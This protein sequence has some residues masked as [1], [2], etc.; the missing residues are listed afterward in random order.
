M[1]NGLSRVAKLSEIT[2]GKAAIIA[3]EL[4]NNIIKHA[5]GKGEILI[6][7]IFEPVAGV[8][9]M[10]IDQGEGMVSVAA[11][12]QDGFSTS[13]TPGT[14]LGA[15][16]RL[17]SVSDIYSVPRKGTMIL[18]QVTEQETIRL[19]RASP[20]GGVCTPYPG[21]ISC[22]DRWVSVTRSGATWIMVA[23]GLG[24][25]ETAQVAADTAAELF[26]SSTEESPAIILQ[27]L[28]GALR[29]TRGAAASILKFD[30]TRNKVTYSG[31][32]NISAVMVDDNVTKH[33]VSHNGT[34]GA[35][36]RKF[37]EFEQPV[38]AGAMVIM[39]SDGLG[40]RWDLK[41]Y[42]GVLQRHPSLVAGLLYTRFKR[43]RDDVTVVALRCVVN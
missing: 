28:H 17:A 14:G 29:S 7:Q 42:P 41:E 13:G 35:E 38:R 34:L 3:T 22:G 6:R 33:L 26:L 12:S 27:H 9:I 15:V 19:R 32:G 5:Q 43:G 40:S 16:T 4:A 24:H 37:H 1:A 10:A 20:L 8:E 36:A 11:C 21:E 25:G 2:A 23:D 30:H 31:I 39:H 18:A